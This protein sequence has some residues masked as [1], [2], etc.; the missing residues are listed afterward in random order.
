MTDLLIKYPTRGRPDLFRRTLECYLRDPFP[1]LLVCIDADDATMN[2]EEMLDY[3]DRQDRVEYHVGAGR[4]KIR[5]VNAGLKEFNWRICVVAS[6]DMIPVRSDYGRRIVEIF[7]EFFPEGDG[8]LHLNDGRTG[9]RLNTLP[10]LDRKYFDRF[11][12]VYHPA[13]V[14][15]WCDNEFQ[16][17]SQRLGR[18]VYCPEVVIQHDWIGT[19]Q[20]ADALLIHNEKFYR[21]DEM[22]YRTRAAKGFPAGE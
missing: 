14:S 16:A 17:V 22:T 19:T 5:A 4:G 6:D 10:I 15:L 18:A 2:N 7:D 8:V 3:L 1:R 9:M 21:Q 11:G 12:Y 20:P 13:Y